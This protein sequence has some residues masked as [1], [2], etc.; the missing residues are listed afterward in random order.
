MKSFPAPQLFNLL[1]NQH[2]PLL[3]F[4]LNNRRQKQVDITN[5]KTLKLRQVKR[6][7]FGAALLQFFYKRKKKKTQSP[8]FRQKER[9]NLRKDVR[10]SNHPGR[11]SMPPK[12]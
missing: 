6:L 9:L 10:F 4:T 11:A 2:T 5:L 1:L 12:V 3:Q 8:K 7:E